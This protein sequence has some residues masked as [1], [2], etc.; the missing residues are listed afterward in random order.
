MFSYVC[1]QRKFMNQNKSLI[2]TGP[3][4]TATFLKL[5]T[6]SNKDFNGKKRLIVDKRPLK[7]EFR[8]IAV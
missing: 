8:F 2:G 5:S 6:E 1:E 7:D 4:T 3:E